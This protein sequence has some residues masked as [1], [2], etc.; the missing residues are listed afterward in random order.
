MKKLLI[1]LFLSS[2]IIGSINAQKVS[3]ETNVSRSLSGFGDMWGTIAQAGVKAYIK[4]GFYAK[5]T[6]G[7]GK[8]TEKAFSIE[9]LQNEINLLVLD[10]WVE[11]YP[12]LYL[13]G[14]FDFGTKHLTPSTNFQVYDIFSFVVGKD[15]HLG[16]K[17][18]IGVDL[19]YNRLKVEN[20]YITG[21][22]PSK[23]INFYGEIEGTIAIPHIFSFYDNSVNFEIN[24]TYKL[25][26]NLRLGLFLNINEG[27]IRIS[28]S[29]IKVSTTIIN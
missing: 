16:E 7:I 28:S 6:Y 22:V 8:A 9:Q 3:F 14:S 29:G 23:V 21:Q 11:N 5:I 12:Y 2:F 1:H 15:F 24:G 18:N 4:K 17:V 27:A 20:T 26:N 25:N 13:S 10:E 19:G